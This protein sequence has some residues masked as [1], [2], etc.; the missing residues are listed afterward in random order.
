MPLQRFQMRSLNLGFWGALVAALVALAAGG[1]MLILL[2]GKAL[3][4][5]A[6]VSWL[7]PRFFSPEFTRWVFGTESI[8]FWKVL[9]MVL[10]AGAVLETVRR[11]RRR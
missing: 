1:V 7:W 6:A 2:F 10:I 3:L 9:V 8:S 11:W 5:S 4:V